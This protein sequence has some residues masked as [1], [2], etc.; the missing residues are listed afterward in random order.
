M[1]PL[2][3]YRRD[4]SYA[5]AAGL[6]PA[7]E[8]LRRAPERVRRVLV[9]PRLGGGEGAQALLSLCGRHGIRVEEAD[10]LLRRISG[11]DNCFAAAVFDKKF[12]RPDPGRS[13]LALVNPMDPGNLGTVL[14]TA[15][16]L[17]FPDAVLVR[18]CADP[19]EPQAVRAG[20][21]AVLSMN[22]SEY[23]GFDEYREAYPGHRI[24]PFMLDGA[25][26]LSEAAGERGGPFCLVFGNEGSGLPPA[27]A[28]F[29]AVKIEQ[30]GKVDSLNLAAAAA[31]GLY[32]FRQ[33]EGL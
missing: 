14:R 18:P 16:G 13:H 23:A 12:E 30:S 26:P 5:Y 24:L 31:I 1:P 10:R 28:R 33:I 7:L 6:F 9:S 22:V 4:L 21:G 32:A 15:L 20:M 19:F 27:F 8:A 25:R 11:K 3:P 17:G 29:G 2:S